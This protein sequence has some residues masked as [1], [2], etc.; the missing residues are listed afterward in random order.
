[1]VVAGT[2][3][4]IAGAIARNEECLFVG[5]TLLAIATG[6]KFGKKAPK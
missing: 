1:M 3:M 5:T 6:S 2:G 4:V